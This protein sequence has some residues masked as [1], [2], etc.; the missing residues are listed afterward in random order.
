MLLRQDDATPP[1]V[2][3]DIGRITQALP[4]HSVMYYC[5]MKYLLYSFRQSRMN[6]STAS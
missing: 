6:N 2:A 4:K 3:P 5:E 1:K